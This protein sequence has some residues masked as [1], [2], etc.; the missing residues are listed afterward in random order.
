M[1]WAGPHT[2]SVAVATNPTQL[3]KNFVGP[4]RRTQAYINNMTHGHESLSLHDSQSR[5]SSARLRDSLTNY[6]LL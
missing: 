5:V 6:F 2:D 1:G 3:P 4:V